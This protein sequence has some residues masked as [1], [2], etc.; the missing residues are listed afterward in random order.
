MIKKQI[1]FGEKGL[2]EL[3][4]EDEIIAIQKVSKG[5]ANEY[6]QKMAYKVIVE[7]LCRIA[8]PAFNPD[9]HITS[10]NEGVRF[11]GVMLA[12]A[13]TA[14]TDN[15]KKRNITNQPKQK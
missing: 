3:F 4:H 15:F 12:Q 1:F 10:F 5:S 14:E 7:K 8:Q 2:S 13:I 9:S 11:I 6:E